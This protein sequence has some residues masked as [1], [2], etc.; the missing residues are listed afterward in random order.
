MDK[1]IYIDEPIQKIVIINDDY[2]KQPVSMISGQTQFL[3]IPST[4]MH[5][6]S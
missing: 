5:K 6:V 1:I 3:E 2:Y 4:L